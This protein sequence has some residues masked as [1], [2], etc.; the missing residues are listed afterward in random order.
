MFTRKGYGL[1]P[2]PFPTNSDGRREGLALTEN[3]WNICVLGER[4]KYQYLNVAMVADWASPWEQF[5]D[6]ELF[7]KDIFDNETDP[8]SGNLTTLTRT[9]QT[10][11]LVMGRPGRV[12]WS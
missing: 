7:V 6:V 8:I 9:T 5:L 10:N 4:N 11:G 2:L 1:L 12:R 3:P